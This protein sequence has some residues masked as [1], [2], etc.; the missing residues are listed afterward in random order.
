MINTT[1]NAFS[2]ELNSFVENIEN[3]NSLQI[4]KFFNRN[5]R[6]INESIGNIAIQTDLIK[7]GNKAL[8]KSQ[9]AHSCAVAFQIGSTARTILPNPDCIWDN[10]PTEIQK[11]IFSE[12]SREFITLYTLNQLLI[13]KKISRMIYHVK[14]DWINANDFCLY[15][16]GYITPKAA[17]AGII[18]HQLTSANFSAYT[19]LNDSDLEELKN[20]S[21]LKKLSLYPANFQMDKAA[22]VLNK[23]SSLESLKL[24]SGLNCT[25]KLID[26]I[27]KHTSIQN[28]HLSCD[29]TCEDEIPIALKNFNLQ[30]L[31]FS[32]CKKPTSLIDKHSNL[33]GLDFTRRL[34][35]FD[36]ALIDVICKLP[37]LYELNLWGQSISGVQLAKIV[38]KHPTLQI[39]NLGRTALTSD[40]FVKIIGK[41]THLRILD[42]SYCIQISGDHLVKIAENAPTLQRITIHGMKIAEDKLIE[43][44]E[45][46]HNLENLILM[47][48]D[49][50]SI[51]TMNEIARKYPML[52]ISIC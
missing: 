26:A 4:R 13:S 20:C 42:I 46:L 17:I 14:R 5:F 30:N 41:L 21:Q 34:L 33:Q 35:F 31:N 29:N 24:Y 47:D 11:Y 27:G 12:L 9:D 7:L 25:E 15:K 8:E 38:D 51:D 44:I 19:S 48:Y 23:I 40:Q 22:D 43:V 16:L 50:Y 18:K 52:Q 36:D 37:Y 39:L 1:A 2:L 3:H 6:A 45:L 10:L 49:K 28:L 32:W